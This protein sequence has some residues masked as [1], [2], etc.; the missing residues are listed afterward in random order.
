[1]GSQ[2]LEA[3]KVNALPKSILVRGVNWLGDAVM[4]TPALQRLREGV[5]GS[6][7]SL[8]THAK[9]RDLWTDYPHV[10]EVIAFEENESVFR[11]ARRLRGRF[12]M[13][14]VLPNS[15]RST[16]E[17]FL[18][19]IPK[20]IGF[21]RGGRSIFLTRAVPIRSDTVP[22]RKRSVAEIRQLAESRSARA[23]FPS[24]AHQLYDHLHLLR[25]IGIAAEPVAPKLHVSDKEVAMARARFFGAQDKPWLGLNPGAEYGPAKRWPSDQFVRAAI[26]VR[27]TADCELVVFGGEKDRT[28]T[29]PIA[30]AT[31]A[32]NLTGRTTL[33]E[34]AACFRVC[35]AL[36]TNDTGPMHLAAAVGTPVIV[37]FGSTAPELTGPGFPADRTS[38]HVLLKGDVPCAPCFR[39]ECPIDFRCMRRITVEQLVASVRTL[40]S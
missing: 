2:S 25:A 23:T 22:L 28:V 38:P 12:E 29:D 5:P 27:R 32:L 39:R 19:R 9:L 10:D 11:I 40:M 3:K 16:L 8:L 17:A 36:L 31:G 4:S 34:L 26:G 15:P 6:R 18:A 33:R 14:L 35:K 37:P 24:S 20:R 7:I 30:A 21:A 13:A 1:L